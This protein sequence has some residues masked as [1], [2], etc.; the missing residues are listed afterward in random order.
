MN[1]YEIEQLI[2]DISFNENMVCIYQHKVGLAQKD[3]YKALEN[4]CLARRRVYN[5]TD[6]LHNKLFDIMLKVSHRKFMRIL[7]GL[8]LG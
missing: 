5:L 1:N 3:I 7:K 2:R 8:G 6:E 4:V